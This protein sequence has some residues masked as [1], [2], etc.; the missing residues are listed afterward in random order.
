MKDEGDE[1]QVRRGEMGLGRCSIQLDCLRLELL[2]LLVWPV[3]VRID[4]KDHTLAAVTGLCIRGREQSAPEH[5]NRKI[6]L[7]VHSR[8]RGGTCGE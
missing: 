1:R 6:R 7:P 8:R 3:P 4:G 2:E 5:E